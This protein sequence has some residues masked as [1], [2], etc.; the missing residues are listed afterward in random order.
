MTRALLVLHNDGI[1][2]RAIQWIKKAP[3]ETRE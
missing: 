3:P 1:R 2:Q